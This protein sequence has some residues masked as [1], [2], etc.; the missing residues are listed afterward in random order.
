MKI[1]SFILS[2]ILIFG[3]IFI[4]P[5]SLHSQSFLGCIDIDFETIPGDIPAENLIISDQFYNSFGLS[6]AL[7]NGKFPLLAEIGGAEPAAFWSQWGNDTPAPGQDPGRF[8]IT[9]DGEL[10][11]TNLISPAL[12]LTF[13][14][15]IDSFAGCILD[16]DLS[17]SFT[18]EALD[19]AGNVLQDFTIVDG[20]PNTGDGT[21]NCWGFNLQGCKGSVYSIRYSGTRTLSGGFGLGMDNFSFCFNNFDF[22]KVDAFCNADFGSITMINLSST[23]LTYSINGSPFQTD[24]YFPNLSP[25][26]YIV[27]TL[28]INGCESELEI[29]IEGPYPLE[30]NSNT[31]QMICDF[32][33]GSIDITTDN[34]YLTEYSIDGV[35]YSAF[36]SFSNLSQGNYNVH[37]IDIN[38][39]D[40]NFTLV[41]EAPNLPVVESFIAFEESCDQM[42]GEV[43]VTASGGTGSILYSLDG[44]DFQTDSIFSSLPSGQYNLI[45][46]DENGCLDSTMVIVERSI[47]LTS[48]NIELIDPDCFQNNGSIFINNPDSTGVYLYTID[49]VFQ[50]DPLF[51]NLSYGDYIIQIDSDGCTID[52]PISLESPICPIYI[53]NVI[54]PNGDFNNDF[55]SILTESGYQ[56]QI[57]VYDIYDRW[58]E[59]VFRSNRFNI[60]ESPNWWDGTFNGQNVENGVYAYYIQVLHPNGAIQDLT[61]DLT[62][63][64]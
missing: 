11:Q 61:G 37:A 24:P 18:I 49:G 43:Y 15:P 22:K 7:E 3:F 23:E 8:F 5:N 58:G 31:S 12:I 6:F 64:R 52:I 54:T 46:Q 32:Q 16:L 38:G 25:G 55:F 42:D 36:G 47:D 10:S 62:V 9:D 51:E 29:E 48:D 33:N 56:V 28:D 13:E 1:D 14:N 57:L 53:P 4:N 20:D 59:L 21:Y 45:I 35:N 50:S 26:I 19:Q 27:K 34:L 17:E 41:I 60:H 63:L 30:V 2:I 44:I 40:T 39:C